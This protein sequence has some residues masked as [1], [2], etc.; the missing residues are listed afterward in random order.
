[1][2]S[3]RI[4]CP[5]F[6]L[7]FDDKWRYQ[8]N[9][10]L[11]GDEAF[12]SL[13]AST[14]STRGYMC[15]PL[16]GLQHAGVFEGDDQIS[17]EFA[18]SLGLGNVAQTATIWQVCEALY[19]EDGGAADSK[20]IDPEVFFKTIYRKKNAEFQ[21]RNG[22]PVMGA[23]YMPMEED[24][25][26]AFG[27]GSAMGARGAAWQIGGLTAADTEPW[28]K[29]DFSKKGLAD[30]FAVGMSLPIVCCFVNW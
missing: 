23:P 30:W 10:A 27:E 22:N 21:N 6:T 7:V 19:R 20:M 5:S 11:N 18:A 1:M 26:E 3:S 14:Q 16:A 9:R 12:A 17:A 29:I 4:R 24:G 8:A 2:M 25:E 13:K 28:K 15:R